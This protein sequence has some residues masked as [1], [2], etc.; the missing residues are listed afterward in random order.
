[1]KARPNFGSV[2]D[3][4]GAAD[5]KPVIVSNI[6]APPPKIARD[7]K[8]FRLPTTLCEDLRRVVFHHSGLQNRRVTETEI[9]EIAIRAFVDSHKL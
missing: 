1:M 4:I 6:P 2:D 5:P 7:Q 8:I 9:V 3:F